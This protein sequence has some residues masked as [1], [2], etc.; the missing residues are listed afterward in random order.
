[1]FAVRLLGSEPA[2]AGTFE[3]IWLT[4]D[5]QGQ[6]AFQHGDYAAAA[7]IFRDPMW[8]GTASYRAGRFKEAADA[9]SLSDTAE[10][11]F[12]LGNALLRLG[13]FEEGINAYAK[14]LEKRKNWP[15]AEANLALA[16]RLFKDEQDNDEPDQP[17]ENPDDVQFDD[18]GKKGKEGS[19]NLGE[20]TS[21][22][23]M[24]NIQSSPADLMARKFAI[25]AARK[26]P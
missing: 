18:K 2:S 3:D 14:A 11:C 13:N 26:T 15:E 22:M 1:M 12:N 10:S 21:E 5:Q 16:K 23:W 19:I 6:I 17:N 20:V 7:A 25:E 4:P 9:F 24:K 8:K